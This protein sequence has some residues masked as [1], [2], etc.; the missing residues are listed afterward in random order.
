MCPASAYTRPG[1]VTRWSQLLAGAGRGPAVRP[2]EQ[3]EP[4]DGRAGR[5]A[6]PVGH[7]EHGQRPVA[8]AGG[9]AA[10]AGQ[11]DRRRQQLRPQRGQ[12]RAARRQPQPDARPVARPGRPVRAGCS[13]PAGPAGRRAAAGSRCR[14]G[15]APRRGRPAPR[16][17]P[18]RRRARGPGRRRRCRCRR[19]RSSRRRGRPRR[20]AARPRRRPRAT[21]KT[22]AWWTIVDVARPEL[23]AGEERRRTQPGVDEEATVFVGPAVRRPRRVR[24]R[25]G[26]RGEPLPDRERGARPGRRGV[27]VRAAG[28]RRAGRGRSAPRGAPAAG[29]P[30]PAV[31]AAEQP[32]DRTASAAAAASQSPPSHARSM[33]PGS[34]PGPIAVSG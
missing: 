21:R 26:Q 24:P 18:S 8:Q 11:L 27:P 6:E 16:P 5:Q 10:R 2:A 31:A 17:P 29:A 1:S 22:I 25:H 15:C 34:R 4:G 32:P 9:L 28:R 23:A 33:G 12:R 20:A 7:V 14:P 30:D 19:S 13:G 3:G